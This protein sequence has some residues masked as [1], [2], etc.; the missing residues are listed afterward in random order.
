MSPLVWEL[1]VILILFKLPVAYVCW[2]AW[3]AIKAEPEVGPQS[4]DAGW[5]PWRRP[6]GPRPRRGGPH[7]TPARRASH[8]V[9][10]PGRLEA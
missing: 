8:R 5:Q 7:G 2:V 6:S 9:R 3:W 4:D 1:V 10:R